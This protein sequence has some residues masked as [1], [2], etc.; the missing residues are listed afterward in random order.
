M[1]DSDNFFWNIKSNV[2]ERKKA[3]PGENTMNW[4]PCSRPCGEDDIEPYSVNTGLGE[5]IANSRSNP[6]CVNAKFCI[7][8]PAQRV[9]QLLQD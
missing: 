7:P 2:N 1:N 6:A 4:K 8:L 3:I 5:Q 9:F